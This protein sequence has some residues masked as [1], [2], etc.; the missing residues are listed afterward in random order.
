MN[1]TKISIH[2]DNSELNDFLIL[3][4]K[5]QQRPNKVI[6]H[7]TFAGNNFLEIINSQNFS[8]VQELIPIEDDYLI[9]EKNLVQINQNI[10]CSFVIIDKNSNNS[11][12]NDVIFYYRNQ[13]DESEIETIISKISECVIDYEEDT[14]NKFNTISISPNSFELDPFYLET[15]EIQIQGRYNKEVIKSVEKLQKKIKKTNRGLSIICGQRGVGKTLLT[16][17][18]CSK[19]DR[20]TIFIPNNMVDLTINNPEFKAFLKKFEK[21]LIV[22]DDCEFLT[23]NQLLKI[24]QF[25]NN[26]LQLTEGFLSNFFNIQIILLFNSTTDEIDENLLQSNSLLDTIEI[27]KLETKV[28]NQLSKELKFNK[29][30]QT[31]TKLID[32]ILNKN[33][34]KT[35]KI[36]L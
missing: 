16:Q 33:Q 35:D 8:K 14:F 21:L 32:V 28:A 36:G 10:Y 26:I 15:D 6:I 25:T 22:I 12:V 24:N 34:V 9:N 4:D 30:Y 17:Y 11:L 18:L 27:D 1:F 23:N 29:N 3:F 5:F 20:L 31:P 7:D 19:I 13:S 2:D